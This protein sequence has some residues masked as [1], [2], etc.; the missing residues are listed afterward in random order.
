M[1]IKKAAWKWI[2]SSVIAGNAHWLKWNGLRGTPKAQRPFYGIL[3][4]TTWEALSNWEIT[5][6]KEPISFW[7]CRCIWRFCSMP[8]NFYIGYRK[9][10]C[11][12][13]NRVLSRFFGYCLTLISVDSDSPSCRWQYDKHIP[14]RQQSIRL[15]HMF[16]LVSACENRLQP[17]SDRSAS[18]PLA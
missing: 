18:G 7:L 10:L 4:N 15:W 17:E 5:I 13:L 12:F 8:V 16:W 1:F 3:K 2:L 14:Y 6:W 11:S 9:A